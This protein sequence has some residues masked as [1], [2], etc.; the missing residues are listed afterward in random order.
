MLY[1]HCL[2]RLTAKK[3]S[4]VAGRKRNKKTGELKS[5]MRHPHPNFRAMLFIWLGFVVRQH[6]EKG[7]THDC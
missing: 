7:Y 1:C 3:I 4:R 5:K 6:L 2:Q